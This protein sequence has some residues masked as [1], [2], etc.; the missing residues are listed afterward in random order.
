MAYSLAGFRRYAPRFMDEEGRPLKIEAFQ[1]RALRDHFNGVPETFIGIPEE[2]GKTTLLAVLGLYHLENWPGV[3]P[4]VP[5]FASARDQ[6]GYLFEQAAGLVE[7]SELTDVFEV[8]RGY[9]IIRL[10]SNQRARIMVKASDERTADGLIPTLVLVDEYHRHRDD[11]AY[12]ISRHKL[13]KRN[14]RMVTISTAGS[15]KDSPL[16]RLREAAHKMPGFTRQGVYNRVVTDEFAWHEWCLDPEDDLD[17]LKLVKKANPASFVTLKYLKTKRASPSHRPARW[18]RFVCGVWTEGEEPW[19]EPQA[20]DRLRVDVGGITEGERVSA[21][22]RVGAGAGIALVAEREDRLAVKA[23]C[24]PPPQSGRLSHEAVEEV[25]REIHETYALREVAYPEQFRRSAEILFSEG[26]P[27]IEVPQRAGRL[28]D[29]SEALYAFIQSGRLAHDGDSALRAQVLA[30]Q[31][32][33]TLT[34]WHLVPTQETPALIALAMA[35]HQSTQGAAE[36][37]VA[38]I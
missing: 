5:L 13:G 14:G 8:K 31:T 18:A 11:G 10:A 32:K 35:C 1:A 30:G 3:D 25:L 29:A 6:A 16:G 2:N 9:R 34:G 4:Y 27:M 17:D 36:P 33:E 7:R 37:M 21:A 19:V 23:V 12:S 26:I 38:F 24:M 20:W 28:A 15:R 22:V